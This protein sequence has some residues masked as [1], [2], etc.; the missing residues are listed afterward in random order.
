MRLTEP[1]TI[2]L[3]I[4]ASFGVSRYLSAL[5]HSSS[6]LRAVAEGIAAGLLWPLAA[7][8]ILIKRLRHKHWN[9]AVQ[10]R[11]ERVH[12]RVEEA[13]RAFAV[14]ASRMLEAMHTQP[15]A[16]R[17]SMEQMLFAL[18]ESAGQYAWLAMMEANEGA[19]PAAHEAELARVSG[20]RGDDLLVAARC[21]HRRNVSRIKTNYQRERQR[22]LLKLA[23][24]RAEDEADSS[25]GRDGDCC[26]MRREAAESR[27]EIYLRAA[28]LFSLLEDERAVRSTAKLIDAECLILRRLREAEDVA[29]TL[30]GH[31]EERC[32]EHPQ[33]ILKDHLRATT[34]TQG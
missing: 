25:Y 24:L 32:T 33:L 20:L 3:A 14:S 34:F 10:E 23:E 7:A 8:A 2:Y 28:D 6:R 18:R 26:S 16:A 9:D 5:G 11:D 21:V 31:G 15:Q 4:G 22:L 19:P 27:L 30:C 1:V 13:A 12:G 29:A 17:E